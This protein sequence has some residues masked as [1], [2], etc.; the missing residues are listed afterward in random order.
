MRKSEKNF[1]GRVAS[2]VA[3]VLLCDKLIRPVEVAVAKWS[4]STSFCV[5]C[6]PNFLTATTTPSL[7]EG[8]MSHFKIEDTG[9]RSQHLLLDFVPLETKLISINIHIQITVAIPN[10]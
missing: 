2:A 1:R 10:W 5:L 9:N 8:S 6:G 4:L 3:A 7:A